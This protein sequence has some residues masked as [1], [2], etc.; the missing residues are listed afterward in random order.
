[1]KGLYVT[2]SLLSV[3]LSVACTG[4]LT[5]LPNTNTSTSEKLSIETSSDGSGLMIPEILNLTIGDTRQLFSISRNSDGSFLGNEEVS[6]TLNGGIGSLLIM[7]S[8]KTATYTASSVGS[9]EIIISSAGKSESINVIVNGLAQPP[10]VTNLQA[11]LTS[12]TSVTLSWDSA[13]GT[14]DSFQIAY[15]TGTDAPANCSSETV[16]L[17]ASITGTSHTITGLSPGADYSVVVCAQN[18]ASS[19]GLSIP[20]AASFTTLLN[21]SV[22]AVYPTNPNWNDYVGNTNPSLSKFHQTDTACVTSTQGYDACIHSGEKLKLSLSPIDSCSNIS[23]TDDLGLFNWSCELIGGFANVVSLGL[24]ENTNL[25]DLIATSP[26]LAWKTNFVSVTQSGSL[27]ARS[28]PDTWW[29]NSFVDLS[30][31]TSI[32]DDA[33]DIGRIFVLNTDLDI[34]GIEVLDNKSAI[35]VMPGSEITL[36]GANSCNRTTVSSV[37]PDRICGFYGVGLS[38]LWLELNI[39][40][41]QES[42]K[43]AI[44]FDDLVH[45]RLKNNK[46]VGFSTYGNTRIVS[47]SHSLI[48][49]KTRLRSIGNTLGLALH[50]SHSLVYD[51]IAI[52]SPF[53]NNSAIQI[54]GD[55]NH[56]V[57]MKIHN[58]NNTSSGAFGISG[59]YSRYSQLLISASGNR[60]IYLSAGSSNIVLSHITATNN[61]QGFVRGN[62]THYNVYNNILITNGERAFDSDGGFVWNNRHYG[63][64]LSNHSEF[65]LRVDENG[66]T[67]II[68]DNFYFDYLG[69]FGNLINCTTGGAT[70]GFIHSTCTDTGIDGSS[71]Y[72]GQGSTATLRL[73]HDPSSSFMG[74]LS[75]EDTS[76]SSDTLGVVDF[77]TTMD[78]FNFDNW[79]RTIGVDGSAFPNADHVGNCSTTGCRI[80]D[81]RLKASDTSFLNKSGN[82]FTSN[83]SFVAGSACPSEVGGNVTITD[84]HSTPM[85]FLKHAVEIMRDGLGND[86]GF[87]ESNEA[88]IYTPNIGVY[89]GSGD[90]LANG[91]CTFTDGAVT[92]VDMYAYPIN[93]EI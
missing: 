18:S 24:K 42:Y 33:S 4:G 77:S 12:A 23:A 50:A 79:F 17:P 20:L 37:S 91:T 63:L 92:G 78:V 21:P 81:W 38:H 48:V 82:G 87:C 19:P 35:V 14:T 65:G 13:G 59:D 27:I 25:S 62:A 66:N 52:T 86:N 75:L 15:V 36:S 83:S 2:I 56:I 40:A 11:S 76:N 88:C 46:F 28:S 29:N 85:T 45:S 70:S 6:W 72:T 74:K 26:S 68:R 10:A 3:F 41:E 44:L 22:E 73:N 71:V 61:M 93:G 47:G 34:N 30:S 43:A 55:Y 89:Q 7:P 64:S 9:S 60:A 39:D 57:K 51:T 69:F 5:N 8:G 54:F 58:S 49:E 16:V 90:Y 53:A 67:N 1:M 32:T 31:V 84:D 80:W